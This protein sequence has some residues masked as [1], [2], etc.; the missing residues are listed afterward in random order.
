MSRAHP[1]SAWKEIDMRT[2]F[3]G[4]DSRAGGA[5][6]RAIAVGLTLTT[7][8]IHVA[9]GGPLFTMTA[10]GYATLAVGLT[11]PGPMARV[12]WLVR[13]ALIGFALA[14]IGGW[15][16]FGARFSLAYVDKAI[17]VALVIVVAVELRMSDGGPVEIA[18]RLVQLPRAVASAVRA[19]G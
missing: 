19:R 3:A 2:T 11:I 4:T 18:R 14:T 8:A 10:I 15:V 16:L 7:A 17:E 12:R 1:G 6:L 9:L 13:L 5:A